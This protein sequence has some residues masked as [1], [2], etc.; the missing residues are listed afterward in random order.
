MEEASES[1]FHPCKLGVTQS[2]SFLI[3]SEYTYEALSLND[4][5]LDPKAIASHQVG[6]HDISEQAV[7]N[8][9]DVIW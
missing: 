8:N 4:A 5:V 6:H 3:K 1:V 2:A 9:G 7:T